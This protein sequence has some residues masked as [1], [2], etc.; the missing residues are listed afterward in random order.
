MIMNNAMKN[1]RLFP[2]RQGY[3]KWVYN[4]G[5]NILFT[6]RYDRSNIYEEARSGHVTVNVWGWVCIHGMGDVTRIEGRFTAAK[7][8][9]ILQEFFLPSLRQRNYPFPHGPVIFVQDRFPIH[10]TRV[11]SEWFRG[12]ENL[13]RLDWPSKGADMNPIENV[14]GNMVNCWVPERERTPAAL[15]DHTHDQWEMFRNKPQLVRTLVASMPNR[16]RE[17]IDKEGGL[18]HY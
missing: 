1:D 7:Y 14:W 18:T 12:R 17:V 15:M 8:I 10:T 4:N 9:D 5:V 11:V 2:Q 6:C 3:L 13:Q 16:L